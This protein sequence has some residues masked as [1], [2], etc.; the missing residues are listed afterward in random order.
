MKVVIGYASGVGRIAPQREVLGFIC[1]LN[2][3][4][5]YFWGGGVVLIRNLKLFSTGFKRRM[6]RGRKQIQGKKRAVSVILL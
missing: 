3:C 2:K 4:V 1:T 5:P 6:V